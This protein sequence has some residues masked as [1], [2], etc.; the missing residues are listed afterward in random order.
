MPTVCDG[1][2]PIGN[3]APFASQKDVVAFLEE[4]CK[5]CYGEVP[6]YTDE[7]DFCTDAFGGSYDSNCDFL[8]VKRGTAPDE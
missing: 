7:V 3:C 2:T 1:I 4:F 6:Q 5:D 8:L